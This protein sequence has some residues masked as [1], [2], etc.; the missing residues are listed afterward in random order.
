MSGDGGEGGCVLEN[1]QHRK[2]D[3]WNTGADPR[4][5]YASDTSIAGEGSV[6]G[7]LSVEM[8]D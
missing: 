1:S 2:K 4:V 6:P 7:G 8:I 5:D 3:G